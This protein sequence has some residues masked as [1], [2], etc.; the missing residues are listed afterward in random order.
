MLDANPQ[1]YKLRYGTLNG[2]F[3]HTILVKKDNSYTHSY[4]RLGENPIAPISEP[5]RTDWDVCFTY[6]ADSISKHGTYPHLI[7]VNP[8]F[9]VYH[10]ITLNQESAEVAVEMETA[11]DDIDF[12]YARK[13]VYSQSDQIKNEFIFWNEDKGQ[14]ELLSNSTIILK[15]QN[16]FYKMRVK[17]LFGDYPSNFAL[18]VALKKL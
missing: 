17:D 16:E 12:F 9:G 18:R 2:K 6:I 11:Y 15:V 13:L 8:F 3:D 14:A 5:K 10:A 4:L 1:G 7:T